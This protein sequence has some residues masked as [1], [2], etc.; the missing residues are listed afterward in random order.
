MYVSL[1][2]RENELLIC[3]EPINSK[4]KVL[5]NEHKTI[6]LTES[7]QAAND[8]LSALRQQRLIYAKN[9]IK[10]HL[11]LFSI[12]NKFS[13]FSEAILTRTDTSSFQEQKLI[14]RRLSRGSKRSKYE[15]RK[16]FF[17][18]KENIS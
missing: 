8:L 17:Y 11:N 14:C 13:A 12:R 15:L 16:S 7:S 3:S 1:Q 18:L 5:S 2:L 6:I 9:V 4:N 10:S